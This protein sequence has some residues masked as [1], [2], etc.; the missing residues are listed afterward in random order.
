MVHFRLAIVAKPSLNLAGTNLPSPASPGKSSRAKV[1]TSWAW[2][3]GSHIYSITI[4]ISELGLNFA[5]NSL[6]EIFSSSKKF[7]GASAPS[8]GHLGFN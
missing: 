1:G 6:P 2:H 3:I 4:A 5:Y 8:G 7:K